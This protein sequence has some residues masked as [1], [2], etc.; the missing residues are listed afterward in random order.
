VSGPNQSPVI[1]DSL[2]IGITIIG[3]FPDTQTVRLIFGPPINDTLLAPV[4]TTDPASGT[5]GWMCRPLLPF[6][7]DTQLQGAGYRA[8][9][10]PVGDWQF[11]PNLPIG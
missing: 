10:A 9:P 11:F 7:T 8:V 3:D 5:G 2:F 4:G 6:V 1:R